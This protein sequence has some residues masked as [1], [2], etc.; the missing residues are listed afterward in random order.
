MP[1]SREANPVPR[2]SN[3]SASTSRLLRQVDLGHRGSHGRTFLGHIPILYRTDYSKMARKALGPD[4]LLAPEQ[5]VVLDYWIGPSSPRIVGIN[6]ETVGI[7]AGQIADEPAAAGQER[8]ERLRSHLLDLRNYLVSNQGGLTNYA[9]AYRRGLRISS[10]PA[11]SGMNHLVNQR[12]GKHQPMR[13]SAE[14]AHRGPL[15]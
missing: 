4:A 2:Q 9:H 15:E 12:M 5:G 13:W 1:G 10:A 8:V 7:S 3:S 11:E 14:G 6:S